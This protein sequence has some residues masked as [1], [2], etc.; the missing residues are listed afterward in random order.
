MAVR[1][2][3]PPETDLDYYAR[4]ENY[5]GSNMMAIQRVALAWQKQSD[6]ELDQD[7]RSAHN[8]A[9]S[10]ILDRYRCVGEST[11]TPTPTTLSQTPSD[12]H[13]KRGSVPDIQTP[14]LKER[15]S[16]LV[17]GYKDSS[18]RSRKRSSV[19]LDA[20]SLSVL[21]QDNEIRTNSRGSAVSRSRS[22]RSFSVTFPRNPQYDRMYYNK[23]N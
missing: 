15:R 8:T 2:S 11:P 23:I 3:K 18:A 1:T 10:K 12:C 17:V 21:L 4:P 20:N 9:L 5:T 7:E 22:S 6:K 19:R 16:S 13:L 14:I